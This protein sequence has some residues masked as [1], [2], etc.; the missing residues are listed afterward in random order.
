MF[1]KKSLSTSPQFLFSLITFISCSCTVILPF[2]LSIEIYVMLV[3]PLA[4]P[5]SASMVDCTFTTAD[6]EARYLGDSKIHRQHKTYKNAY[7]LYT[8]I[9]RLVHTNTN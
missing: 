3:L 4:N 7:Y 8:Y 1:Q 9:Y 5:L 2:I 6:Q